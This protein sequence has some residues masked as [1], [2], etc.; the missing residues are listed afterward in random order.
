M[1][2]SNLNLQ[3]LLVGS[4]KFQ[5]YESWVSCFSPSPL[6]LFL[7]MLK[8]FSFITC[9]D[10]I[11][12]EQIYS[13]SCHSRTDTLSQFNLFFKLEPELYFEWYLVTFKRTPGKEEKNFLQLWKLARSDWQN[14]SDPPLNFHHHQLWLHSSTCF[15]G[16]EMKCPSDSCF[17]SQKMF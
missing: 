14:V 11:F 3:N 6:T 1:Q 10:W 5:F 8:N 17:V 7:V 13:F 9:W 15:G 4:W 12:W 2:K 16:A